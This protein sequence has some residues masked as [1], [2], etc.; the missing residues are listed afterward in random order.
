MAV[1]WASC[2]LGDAVDAVIVV[3]CIAH[4]TVAK[5]QTRQ[6]SATYLCLFL[7]N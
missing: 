2:L 7:H 1:L 5:A 4:M 6:G 3:A